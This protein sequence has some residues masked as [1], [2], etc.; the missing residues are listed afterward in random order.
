[1]LNNKKNMSIRLEN[2]DKRKSIVDFE[3]IW[4]F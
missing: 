1:M 3:E 2:V 4:F